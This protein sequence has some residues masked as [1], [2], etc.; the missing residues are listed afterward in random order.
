MASTFLT[1]VKC[2]CINRIFSAIGRTSFARASVV[3][4]RPFQINAVFLIEQLAQA[5]TIDTMIID[6]QKFIGQTD[7]LFEI[8]FF[9]F[10]PAVRP[11]VP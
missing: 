3:S 6:A 10:A 4:I 2:L 1:R 8:L 11:C 7:K 5:D 9:H